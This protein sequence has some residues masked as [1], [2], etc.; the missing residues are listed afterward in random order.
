MYE[1]VCVILYGET[2]ETFN[3]MLFVETF[4][5][6]TKHYGAHSAGPLSGEVLTCSSTQ[7][8]VAAESHEATAADD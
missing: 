6:I 8:Q 7:R 5:L 1:K 4:T 2:T 3:Q